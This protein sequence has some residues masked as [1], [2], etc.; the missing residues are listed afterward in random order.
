MPP[1]K[2]RM[3]EPPSGGTIAPSGLSQT[4]E[5]QLVDHVHQFLVKASALHGGAEQRQPLL[6]E[7]LARHFFRHDRGEAQPEQEPF[8]ALRCV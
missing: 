1:L 8:D 6:G 2:N 3:R 4:Q 7:N 5:Q